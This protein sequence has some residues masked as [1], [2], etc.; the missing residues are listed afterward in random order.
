MPTLREQYSQWNSIHA[1]PM[2]LVPIC[3]PI[4]QTPL[5]NTSKLTPSSHTASPSMARR[6]LFRTNGRV[7]LL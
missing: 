6:C 1:V 5:R 7:S 2:L 4:R 3:L